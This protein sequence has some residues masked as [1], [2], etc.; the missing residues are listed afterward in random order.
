MSKFK[1]CPRSQLSFARGFLPS[2]PPPLLFSRALA[3]RKNRTTEEKGNWQ[4][5][6]SQHADSVSLRLCALCSSGVLKTEHHNESELGNMVD[7]RK[8]KSKR[9][10]RLH[11]CINL[12]SRKGSPKLQ[13]TYFSCFGP[14]WC[15]AKQLFPVKS[16]GFFWSD[17]FE[18]K[19]FNFVVLIEKWQLDSSSYFSLFFLS[20]NPQTSL[21]TDF[22]GAIFHWRN[23]SHEKCWRRGLKSKT[24]SLPSVGCLS[25]TV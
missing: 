7:E 21:S 17:A 5:V 4:P 11:H 13:N 16:D 3:E 22:T 15:V 23:C 20:E 18:V 19:A 2:S 14:G 9:L 10:T 8:H 12:V 6:R 25:F 1:T 24:L